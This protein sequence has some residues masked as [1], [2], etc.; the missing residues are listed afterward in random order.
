MPRSHAG[1]SGRQQ[2]SYKKMR[3]AFTN[4]GLPPLTRDAF[5]RFPF[6]VLQLYHYCIS[7][8]TEVTHLELPQQLI[9]LSNEYSNK[10]CELDR[11]HQSALTQFITLTLQYQRV[12][13]SLSDSEEHLSQCRAQIT[14]LSGEVAEVN[15]QIQKSDVQISDLNELCTTLT[16]QL[17]ALQSVMATKDESICTLEQFTNDLQ[18][19]IEYLQNENQVLESQNTILQSE[20]AKLKRSFE[21]AFEVVSPTTPGTGTSS[22]E[23]EAEDIASP[24]Q[25]DDITPP[26]SPTTQARIELL[27]LNS[28][29]EEE[30]LDDNQSSTDSLPSLV[31]VKMEL[32]PVPVKPDSDN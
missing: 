25:E 26:P 15:M 29:S 18:V 16:S 12:I 4:L 31:S 5:D 3:K 7:N 28:E 2:F 14:S 30:Q 9:L 8:S 19:E 24:L 21:E 13:K 32:A 6:S 23:K 11:R 20:N 27:G 1:S 22:E 10:C 17:K